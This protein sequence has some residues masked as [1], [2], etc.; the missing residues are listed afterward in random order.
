M[1][2]LSF[3]QRLLMGVTLFS[4]FFGAGNLIFPPFTGYRAGSDAVPAFLGLISTAVLF[5]VLGIIATA[6]AGGMDG[7]CR[8][9][10]PQFS[11]WFTLVIY[12]CI[13][14]LLAIPRTASMAFSMMS[15]ATAPAQSIS[16]GPIS[17][18]QIL[19]VVFSV[20]FF[21]ASRF[22]A[23]RPSHLKDI[24]GKILTP[25]LLLLVLVLFSAGMV[26]LPAETGAPQPPYA[27][28]PFAA[29]F[30]EGYNT[31]DALAGL[32]FGILVVQAIR[33]LGVRAPGDVAVSTVCAGVFS[34]ALMAGIY[35]LVTLVGAQ[36]RGRFAAAANGG[37]A[38][39]Q[40]AAA[41]F[42]RAGALILAATVTVACLKTAVGL[43][44]SCGETFVEIFPHG[45][46][47]RVW[48]VG[49]CLLSFLI[50]NLGLDAILAW[51][52]PVLMALYP[53]AIVLILLTLAGPLYGDDRAVL[54]GGLGCTAA[55]AVLEFLRALPAGAAPAVQP[56]VD[57]AAAWLP[58]YAK[59]FGWVLP[60]AVGCAAG[61]VVR[62]RRSR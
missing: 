11:K 18:Q 41:Y 34:S 57:W 26:L 33:R 35:L 21:A 44:T 6:R 24:L 23:Q 13:G 3:R 7:L 16:L 9:V 47:Y 30:V 46:S 36:S 42:G 38:L 61:L 2:R 20:V 31:M 15:F 27:G 4:M 48:A 53:L 19:A 45:P 28:A 50:A 8:K 49:F 43:I 22:F 51:S 17:A 25:I 5:P 32:A 40:I 54:R 55:A 59:G 14:P 12:L 1:T 56:V 29:G 39:A 10:H 60:A 37:E 52:Q 58:L 62:A